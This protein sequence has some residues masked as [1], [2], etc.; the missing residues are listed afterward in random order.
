MCMCT[1]IPCQQEQTWLSKSDTVHVLSRYE[2]MYAQPFVDWT[3]TEADDPD[4][5]S[6]QL[7]PNNRPV[8]RR[9]LLIDPE[10]RPL[11][12][13]PRGS[14]TRAIGPLESRSAHAFAAC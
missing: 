5:L 2:W 8:S 10:S 11:L 9:Q 14:V 12:G 4:S 3:P 7:D 1:D 13:W 6:L